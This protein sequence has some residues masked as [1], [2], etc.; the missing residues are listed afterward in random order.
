[1]ARVRC[2]YAWSILL[3]VLLL[4]SACTAAPP[5]PQPAATI[6]PVS[7]A[8]ELTQ[9]PVSPVAAMTATPQGTAQVVGSGTHHLIVLYTND[10]HGWIAPVTAKNGAQTG[11]DALLAGRWQQVEGYRPG[12]PF[13]VLS[14]GDMWTGPAISTWF[15]GDSAA[16]MMNALGYQAAAIGNHE[17][18]FGLDTLRR[19]AQGAKFP[20]LAANLVRKTDGQ[21]PDF[22]RPFTLVTVDGL[23][24]GVVGLSNTAT[25]QTTRPS[26]VADFTFLPYQ[27]A[28]EQWVPQVRAAGADFVF[29]VGHICAT[30]MRDLAPAAQKLGVSLI[31]GGHC[32][33]RIAT[34][35]AGIPLVEAGKYLESY[36][37][38]DLELDPARHAVLSQK[39]KIVDVAAGPEHATPDPAIAARVAVWQEK[40][41][42]ALGEEIGYTK[43]GLPAKS[44]LL[45]N[46]VTDA[47]L[48]AY[49]TAQIAVNNAG[50][51]RQ[52]LSAG[53]IRL[54]D[55]VGVLPFN[56]TLVDAA[57][58][59]AELEENLSCCGGV[60]GGVTFSGGRAMLTGAKGA[61]ER[62]LGRGTTYHVLIND[63]MAGGGD[64]YK[65]GQQDP[66]AYDTGIDW[67]QP[68]IDY[69][70]SLH[71]SEANPLEAHLDGQARTGK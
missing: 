34:E 14:G 49:P 65:F 46:L 60:V 67:R 71:T 13:L 35:A 4:G 47:W 64:R 44:D 43:S 6:R 53:P 57:V 5:L 28:L 45:F 8:P 29:V 36:A 17:F 12:G 52:G 3:V 19:H 66:K 62:P 58:T 48:A 39:A 26:N 37:R 22:A 31:A 25:P 7:T 38:I 1:M 20:Y 24:I 9:P 2:S 54:R 15:N 41:D 11:G 23:R 30:E 18:D 51:Y 32:H 10:E 55:I 61:A 40:T 21:P 56:D 69:I 33:E 63:F 27:Q 59:G 68:V 42:T 70:K 50:S 16:E